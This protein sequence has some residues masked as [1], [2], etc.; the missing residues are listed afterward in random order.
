MMYLLP[1]MRANGLRNMWRSSKDS[2]FRGL[3]S[4]GYNFPYGWFYSTSPAIVVFLFFLSTISLWLNKITTSLFSNVPSFFS[5]PS[6]LYWKDS[7]LT[8]LRN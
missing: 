4:T 5:S 6:V 1:G 8:R 7:T 2:S 3:V